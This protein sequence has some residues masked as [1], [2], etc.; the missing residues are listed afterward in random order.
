MLPHIKLLH[1][2]KGVLEVDCRTGFQHRW[3]ECLTEAWSV[4]GN[5]PSIEFSYS[6]RELG[7]S[8]CGKAFEKKAP[9]VHH[10]TD[11]SVG[12]P[13]CMKCAVSKYGFGSSDPNYNFAIHGA[14]ED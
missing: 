6:W 2:C 14:D 5:E 11:G 3:R 7:C 10:E 9:L 1:D 12:G 8:E 13:W 4:W